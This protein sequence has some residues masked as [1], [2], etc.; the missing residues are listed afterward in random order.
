VQQISILV[1]DEQRQDKCLKTRTL[2]E[3]DRVQILRGETNGMNSVGVLT[4]LGGYCRAHVHMHVSST[5][6]DPYQKHTKPSTTPDRDSLKLLHRNALRS[7]P[8]QAAKD[9]SSPLCHLRGEGG[10]GHRRQIKHQGRLPLAAVDNCRTGFRVELTL[11]QSTVRH[12][13][14]RKNS[15]DFDREYIEFRHNS[16]G[17]PFLAPPLLQG[18]G[19]RGEGS[20]EPIQ[21]AETGGFISCQ[22]VS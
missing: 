12:L 9:L 6:R 2:P 10:G 5:R 14:I 4:V 13:S 19:G 22:P 18:G 15:L 21:R 1:W 8:H 7:P 20:P 11:N 3:S 16:C 17:L